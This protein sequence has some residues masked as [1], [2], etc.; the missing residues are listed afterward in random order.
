MPNE[1]SKAVSCQLEQIF[2]EMDPLE[3][4]LS[5]NGTVVR[6]EEFQVLLQKW[7]ILL[8]KSCAY[9]SQGN[10]MIERNHRTIKTMNTMQVQEIMLQNF[11]LSV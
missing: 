8:Q 5:D 9:R 4:L 6:S 2:S 3:F 11:L 10:G 7:D 1:I